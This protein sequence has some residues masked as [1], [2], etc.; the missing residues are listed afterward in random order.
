MN[1]KQNWKPIWV[2]RITMEK[3]CRD[4]INASSPILNIWL[5][6]I[7]NC[8]SEKFTFFKVQ[9]LRGQK[10]IVSLPVGGGVAQFEK[11]TRVWK[12][13]ATLRYVCAVCFIVFLKSFVSCQALAGA[14][15]Q[16]SAL[17]QLNLPY[18]NMGNEGVKAWCLVRLGSWGGWE[19]REAKEGSR[20]H[21]MKKMSGKCRKSMQCSIDSEICHIVPRL[22]SKS[23]WLELVLLNLSW[24]IGLK[25]VMT[26]YD[27]WLGY[28]SDSGWTLKWFMLLVNLPKLAASLRWYCRLYRLIENDR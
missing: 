1:C 20:R 12:H 8:F 7:W 27:N 16:N 10:R 5:K 4:I 18:N 3:L 9:K 26:T 21:R 15:K 23:Q 6:I 2:Y 19:W 24:C 25:S 22:S 17:T 11:Q 28:W 13:F 14:L